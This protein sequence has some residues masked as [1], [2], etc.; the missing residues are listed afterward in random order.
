VLVI[1]LLVA[2]VITE[3]A[4]FKRALGDLNSGV[5]LL[6]RAKTTLGLTPQD[7]T[8]DRVAAAASLQ[9]RAQPL[10]IKG[11]TQLH[12]DPGLRLAAGAPELSDQSRA[13]LDLCDAGVAAGAAFGDF[14]KVANA[15]VSQKADLPPGQRL[16]AMLRAAQAPLADA[17]AR[18]QPALRRLDQDSKLTLVGPL[19]LRISLA[20]RELRQPAALA[21]AWSLAGRFLP[22]ALGAERPMTYLVL[23]ENPSELRPSGGLI[24]SVGT[25][26]MTRGSPTRLDIRDYDSL[27][28]LFKQ[29]FPV[30][31][32]LDRYLAF[33][34][35]S[36]E[37]GDAG[38]DPD[39]PNTARL[40]EAMYESA[41]PSDLQ[42]TISIDPYAVA[43]LMK[44]TGPVDVPGYGRFTSDDFF[45]RLNTIVNARADTAVGKRALP[46][47]AQQVL[48]RL[49]D[50]PV[51]SWPAILSAL[52]QQAAARHVQIYLHDPAS[53]QALARAGYD[54]ALV[55]ARTDDYLMLVDANVGATK[56]DWYTH[57]QLS[58]DTEVY[59]GGLSRHE[60]RVTYQL[61]QPVD[62]TDRLLNPGDGAYRDYVRF[63]LPEQASLAGFQ[64]LVDGKLVAKSPDRVYVE[65]GKQ[66]VGAFFE[67]PRGH[68]AELR[69]A[70][71]VPLAHARRYSFYLQKQA[72]VPELPVSLS[73][74]F[75]GG[76]DRKRLQLVSDQGVS[77][78]W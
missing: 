48:A 41:V 10:L 43:A 39:F 50:Q 57:K 68:Q 26:T 32:P 20:A 35:N 63:Y 45:L 61:P 78:R 59:A 64:L 77:Y 7:W 70:Y 9:A 18:L 40:A 37:L 36:L 21:A 6:D 76:V 14:I 49:L 3:T 52:Q 71:E 1:A 31:S 47:V 38:W 24:G 72:G 23:L 25:L 29:R 51:G 73:F 53:E 34:D 75:P 27:N 15:Y 8:S 58:L 5:A 16:L 4:G 30:P 22:A 2:A 74:S 19:R 69:L 44:V 42:G 56:G 60:L 67:L 55:S 65:H 12:R 17:D 46:V 11:C 28:P 13:T 33:Y 54:G 66:V 62:D